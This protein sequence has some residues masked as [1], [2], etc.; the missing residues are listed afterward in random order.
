MYTHVTIVYVQPKVYCQK[1]QCEALDEVRAK[2]QLWL[3][4]FSNRCHCNSNK[5]QEN[6]D[7]KMI[8]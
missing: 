7:F 1:I 5:L 6:T 8:L 4:E 3:H 2:I